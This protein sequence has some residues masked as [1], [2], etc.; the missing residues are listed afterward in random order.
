MSNL[1]FAELSPGTAQHRYH[2]CKLE[3][4]VFAVTPLFLK[5]TCRKAED[6]EKV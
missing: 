2:A 4:C 3:H 5:V 1:C 6:P